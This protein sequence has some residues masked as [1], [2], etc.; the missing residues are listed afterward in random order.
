MAG[1]GFA[2]DGRRSAIISEYAYIYWLDDEFLV[3][4]SDAQSGDAI[5]SHKNS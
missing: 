2:R 4:N 3:G 1:D 5:K